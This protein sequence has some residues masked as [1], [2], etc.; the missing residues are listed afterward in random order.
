MVLAA[1]DDGD[2]RTPA[3]LKDAPCTFLKVTPSHLPLLEALDDSF[4]PSRELMLGGETLLGEA[5]GEWRARHPDVRVYNGYG[6]TETTVTCT[7]HVIA[8]GEPVG[9][10]PLPIGRAMPNTRLYVLDEWLR[11]VPVGVAGELYVMRRGCRPRVCASAGVDRG[12]VRVRPV[13]PVGYAYVPYG[14]HREVELD[15]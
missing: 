15:G 7:Q 5:L 6:P 13:R 11:P 12:A 14:R 2:P 4:S 9:S 3:A 1:L 10:G 8:A